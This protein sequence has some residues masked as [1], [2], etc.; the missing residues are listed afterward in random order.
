MPVLFTLQS[1]TITGLTTGNTYYVFRSSATV[2]KLCSTL[3][4]AQNG[5]FIDLTAKSSP[6]F[7]L[8]YSTAARILGEHS[9]EDAHAQSSTEL[10]AH[11][12]TYNYKTVSAGSGSGT[13][14]SGD[15][16]IQ[17]ASTGG[18]VAMNNL[19]SSSVWNAMIKL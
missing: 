2:L 12:H 19:Q 15:T 6:V 13:P 9:G 4:N 16:T 17:T 18:N 14:W 3:A 5:T 7:T 11:T 10:L 8:V 1:G